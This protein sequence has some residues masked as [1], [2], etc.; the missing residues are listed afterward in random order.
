MIYL[1]VHLFSFSTYIIPQVAGFV[2]CLYSIFLFF[3]HP[4]HSLFGLYTLIIPH[5]SQM[6]RGVVWYGSCMCLIDYMVWGRGCAHEAG[7]PRTH[8]RRLLSFPACPTVSVIGY[9]WF[10]IVYGECKMT[11][12]YR[13][14]LH[15]FLVQEI[16][17]II[18]L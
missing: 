12:I 3:Y 7:V 13:F 1:L 18:T 10:R 4:L 11:S 8:G 17:H 2:K 6:S 9:G 15:S 16:R 14:K 5:Y